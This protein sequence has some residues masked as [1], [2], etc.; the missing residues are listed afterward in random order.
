MCGTGQP[1]THSHGTWRGP[2]VSRWIL[3]IAGLR[4]IAHML[5]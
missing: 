1:V 3:P 2:I 4:R 5:E